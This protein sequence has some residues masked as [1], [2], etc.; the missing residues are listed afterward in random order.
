[1]AY[2][3]TYL[4]GRHDVTLMTWERAGTPSFFPLSSSIQLIQVGLLD[5]AGVLNRTRRILARFVAISREIRRFRPH[6]VLSFM[7]TMN[8]AAVVGSVGSRTPLVISERIDPEHHKIGL[9]KSLVRRLLYPLADCCVVQTERVKSYFMR[10]PQPNVVVIANPVPVPIQQADP[11]QPNE[12]GRFRIIALGRLER[13]KGF[14][15][16]ID[17]FSRLAPS[18]PEWDLAIF[19]GGP[20]RDLLMQRI[21]RHALSARIQLAGITNGPDLELAASH[22]FAFPSR[23]EGF[24]NAL[25]EGL[26]AGLPAVGHCN[27]S[28]VEEM[29]IEGTTGLLVDQAAG[30]PAFADALRRLMSSADLRAQLGARARSHMERWRPSKIL[31]QWEACLSSVAIRAYP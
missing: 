10:R 1:M 29:I 17:A 7:D 31:E 13:Q 5:G 30:S 24:P 11:G 23:F 19:G 12:R 2:V 18:F 8:L 27:V 4:A 16:L 26:A 22:I 20:D 25:A 6:V 14:D 28:G 3:G 9:T 21:A 15:L